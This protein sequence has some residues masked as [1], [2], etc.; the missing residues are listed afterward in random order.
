M[1]LSPVIIFFLFIGVGLV[2]VYFINCIKTSCGSINHYPLSKTAESTIFLDI[3]K[4]ALVIDL[5]FVIISF[6]ASFAPWFFYEMNYT[7]SNNDFKIS[8]V[9]AT[10]LFTSAILTAVI[11]YMSVELA[12]NKRR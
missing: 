11:A 8:T 4:V 6:S 10:N 1:T 2:L 12:N 7:V 9:E 3:L 5:V